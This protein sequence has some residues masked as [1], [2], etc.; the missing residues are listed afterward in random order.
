VLASAGYPASAS[1]G[2]VI[3]G[4]G[5]VGEHVEVTHAGTARG[6]DGE[7]V[8]A[9]GRVLSVTALGPTARDARDAAYAAAH[10]IAFDGRQMRGDIALRAVGPA[11]ALGAFD[12]LYEPGHLERL[13]S[14]ERG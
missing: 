1:T 3:S 2:D 5:D 7:L 4:L 8:T 9:G 11:G 10:A 12:G 13:R 14:Q 6:E